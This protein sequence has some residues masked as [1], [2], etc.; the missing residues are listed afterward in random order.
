MDVDSISES[1][2]R[3]A[4]Y[5]DGDFH[6]L[7]DD[8]KKMEVAEVDPERG[9]IP[10][11][12]SDQTITLGKINGYA[13]EF[14]EM[15]AVHIEHVG[16]GGSKRGIP[17]GFL[18]HHPQVV[19]CYQPKPDKEQDSKHIRWFNYVI[20]KPGEMVRRDDL[21]TKEN[22]QEPRTSDW[23]APE[24]CLAAKAAR[25]LED[26]DPPDEGRL[27][28]LLE[29]TTSRSEWEEKIDLLRRIQSEEIEDIEDW[30]GPQQELERAR[31]Y[32][33]FSRGEYGEWDDYFA[34]TSPEEE[35][36]EKAINPNADEQPRNEL[37]EVLDLKFSAVATTGFAGSQTVRMFVEAL[38]DA[39]MHIQAEE[40]DEADASS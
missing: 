6:Y 4:Q 19:V 20:H 30:D 3:F 36:A 40:T 8:D 26:D 39:G 25:Q 24:W 21:G 7:E 15:K 17:E 34:D 22:K 2:F 5:F 11:G 23:I 33:D 10:S 38:Q 28:D 32:F 27:Y 14:T 31:W 13:Q 9:I 37:C 16:I 18:A 12:Y 1:I 35:L 29:R